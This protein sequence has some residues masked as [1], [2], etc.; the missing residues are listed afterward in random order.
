AR[1]PSISSAKSELEPHP[2]LDAARALR[3][4]RELAKGSV[5]LLAGLVVEDGAGV[6]RRELVVVE[7][8][9]HL[10]AELET[11]RAAQ[12]DVLEHGDV[13]VLEAYSV[14]LVAV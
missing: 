9:V 8:V 6:G 2:Q 3:G 11:T 5:H 7:G 13:P 12:R 10:Q 1:A 4:A 14:V